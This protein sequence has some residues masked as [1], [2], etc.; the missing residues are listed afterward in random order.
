[1]KTG[2]N[3]RK[4]SEMAV[5]GLSGTCRGTTS[6]TGAGLEYFVRWQVS[7]LAIYSLTTLEKDWHSNLSVSAFIVFSMP[8][9]AVASCASAIA[10]S[11]QFLPS[12]LN[13]LGSTNLHFLSLFFAYR[14]PFLITAC[15]GIGDAYRCRQI[16]QECMHAWYAVMISLL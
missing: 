9:C 8:P 16:G 10:S 1:M 14:N 2:D 13:V 7:Q 11:R 5:Q 12:N 6:L 15:A 4:S 3:L